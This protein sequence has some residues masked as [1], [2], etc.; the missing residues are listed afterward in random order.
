V[1]S[2]DF[3]TT[4]QDVQQGTAEIDHIVA[5]RREHQPGGR[6]AGSVFVNPAPG[7]GSAGALIDAAGLR[8]FTSGG[9]HVS[10]KHANF[11]QASDTASAS[12][13]IAVMNHVQNIVRE[14]TGTVLRSE[15]RLVGF[16]DDI[17]LQFA[18]T[19]HDAPHFMSARHALCSMLGEQ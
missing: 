14:Q 9:A 1:V 4:S 8:G 15:V 6:N 12:D 18:D 7:A 16:A 2:A 5:W 3:T 13:I 17:A 19:Q 11:I 10:E